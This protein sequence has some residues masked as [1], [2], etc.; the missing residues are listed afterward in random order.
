MEETISLFDLIKVLRKR[1]LLILGITMASTFIAAIIT[2]YFMKPIYEASTQ[3]LVNQKQNEQ[4]AQIQIQ[5]IQ[6]NIQLINTY[7]VIIKSPFILNKVI[8][9]LKLNITPSELSKQITVSNSNN[10]QVV[11]I[12]VENE[13]ASLAVSI[14]NSV[15]EV[16]QSEIKK[17]MNVDN[18]SILSPAVMPKNPK[19][20]K[21]NKLLNIT[22]GFVMGLATGILLS[23]LREYLD[24]T[25]KTEQDVEELLKLPILGVI[26]KIPDFSE[27]VKELQKSRRAIRRERMNV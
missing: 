9:N 10:S 4:R 13:Q 2:F 21:P 17:I 24:T 25:V 15:A 26:N 22:I 5:D 6:A 11:N 16:F 14:A 7:S 12:S 27:E 23:F 1:V 18:V 3:I 19:P 20:V 8:E